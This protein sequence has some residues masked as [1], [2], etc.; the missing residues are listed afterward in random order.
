MMRSKAVARRPRSP[1]GS[2]P[3]RRARGFCMRRQNLSERCPV[4]KT[5]RA[6][7]S[8]PIKSFREASGQSDTGT[9]LP[10]FHRTPTYKTT[11]FKEVHLSGIA[12][13]GRAL[14]QQQLGTPSRPPWSLCVWRESE[15]VWVN[16]GAVNG[17]SVCLSLCRAGAAEP[18]RQAGLRRGDESGSERV[19]DSRPAAA[20]CRSHRED[21]CVGA[22]SSKSDREHSAALTGGLPLGFLKNHLPLSERAAQPRSA[23]ALSLTSASEDD[24]HFF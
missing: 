15:W 18:R 17:F 4:C 14:L 8:P 22:L 12:A 9:R 16:H 5:R 7:S 1:R 20:T 6:N 11:V 13:F 10:G 19:T 24:L 21:S 23:A 2:S 3:R